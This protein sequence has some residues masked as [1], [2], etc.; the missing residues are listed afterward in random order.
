M[1]PPRQVWLFK[2]GCWT[3]F[4]TAALHLL[5]HLLVPSADKPGPEPA[6][7]RPGYLV[8]VPGQ[9]IPSAGEVADG[10]SLAFSLLLATM[11]AAGIVVAHRGQDDPL[12]L[13]GVARAF[14]IGSGVLLVLSV[15][16]FFSL[17]S[18]AIAAMALCFALGAVSET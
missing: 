15:L 1:T 3:A 17:Q 18:F 7:L 4:A 11:A 10:F 16:L 14:A 12:L 8:L 2:L 9:P 5:A 6:D 13:R